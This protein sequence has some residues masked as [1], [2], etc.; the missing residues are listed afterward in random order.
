MPELPEVETIKRGLNKYVS[1][2][3]ISEVAVLARKIITGDK[4]AVSGGRVT[5][6][7]RFGKML[8]ID[9][10]NGKS[11]AVH[12]KMTGRLIYRGQRQPRDLETEAE[13]DR[14]PNKHTHAVFRFKNGDKLYYNDLRKF[15]WIKIMETVE[16]EKLPFV[17]K[18]GPEPLRDLTKDKFIKIISEAS[19]AIKIV[20]ID[21]EKLSGVGN[22]YA[23][24]ALSCAGILPTRRARDLNRQEAG[25]LVECVE[26]VIKEGIKYRGSSTD[27]YRDLLGRKGEF[28]NHYYA[29]DREG[30]KCKK[31]GCSGKIVKIK[32]A[33]R[34]TY[35]CPRCQ[36]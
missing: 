21:Q 15:G 18:L 12:L 16:V 8:S 14:L 6:V 27:S 4:Q 31:R 19:R 34:G 3:E 22:I 10:S 36:K 5:G 28:Q 20:L 29:Y 35:Y 17:V 9:L 25:K 23:N 2:L 1:G 30:G 24:E 7:R 33:G 11:L 32:L 26:K 13:F